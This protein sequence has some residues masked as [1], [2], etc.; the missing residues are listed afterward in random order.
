MCRPAASAY[1]AHPCRRAHE[2]RRATINLNLSWQSIR[3]ASNGRASK[4]DLQADGVEN[5]EV[6]RLSGWADQPDARLAR[7]AG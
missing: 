5:W 6:G 7:Q 2:S 1:L 3:A 4:G